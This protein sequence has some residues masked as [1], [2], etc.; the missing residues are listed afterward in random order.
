VFNIRVDLNPQ[1]ARL[2]L[3]SLGLVK[4]DRPARPRPETP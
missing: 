1:P 4:E 3:T 2:N